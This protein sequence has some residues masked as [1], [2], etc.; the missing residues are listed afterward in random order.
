M[1]LLEKTKR[2]SVALIDIGAASVGGA[3]AHYAPLAQPVILYTA[4]V[5]IEYKEGESPEDSMVRALEVLGN[6]MVNHGAPELHAATGSARLASVVVSV[7][8]PWQETKIR[9]EVKEEKKPF[10]FTKQLL[11]EILA[12]DLK[13]HPERVASGEQ[14]IATVLNGYDIPNPVGKKTLKAELIILSSTLERAV[15]E[16]IQKTLR[17]SFHSHDITLTS[18]MP[19]AF[20]VL[21]DLFPHEKDFLILDVKAT[22]SE[23]GY[24]RRKLLVN[25]AS[26]PFGT[27]D[28]VDAVTLAHKQELAR[29][30]DS[31]QGLI[32][33]KRNEAFAERVTKAEQ[34]WL[35][36]LAKAI[37]ECTMHQTLPRTLFLLADT[38]SRGFLEG[39]LNASE[40]R[41]VWL[42]NDPLAII[43]LEPSHFSKKVQVRGS[44][45]GDLFLDMMALYQSKRL[46]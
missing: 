18:F 29:A 9:N 44:A 1:G 35:D 24:V 43:S 2:Q 23:L 42:S 19:L 33:L 14:V 21:R 6:I 41:N 7:G 16:K 17:R 36:A 38:Q 45:A 10:L 11:E 5:P 26:I 25:M 28:L 32:Q 13:D 46:G 40:L 15:A 39:A 27:T 34:V 30:G 37:Y 20:T 12:R 22:S 31:E 3:Y 8:A 4:R